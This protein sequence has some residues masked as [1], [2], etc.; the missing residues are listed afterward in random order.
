MQG[1]NR[2]DRNVERS[3][4]D[5]RPTGGS[6]DGGA[7]GG[8]RGGKPTGKPG[9]R[10]GGKP[11]GKP[12]ARSGGRPGDK[13]G[14]RPGGRPTGKP[15]PRPGDRDSRTSRP[16]RPQ[17]PVIPEDVDI[18]DLDP[19]VLNE[20]RTL[21]E[22][23]R[24]KVAAHLAAAELLLLD[25]DDQGARAHTKE[26]KR[27]A[28][29]VAAVR[30]AAGIT[31]YRC[32]DYAD[33]LAELRA[34]RRMTGD[35]SF[36]PMMADCE[37]GLGRP[38]RA[39]ELLREIRGGDPALKVEAQIVAAGARSDM[40]QHEAALVL[41]DIPELTSLPAGTERARLQYAYASTLEALGRD[42]ESREWF[43]KAAESDIDEAT[44]ASARTGTN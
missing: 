18:E 2:E 8:K 29:R 20:L 5:R 37:R 22:E 15:G 42:A 38:E 40:G 9:P 13:P 41:L 26:A 11:N 33:A 35:D 36:V 30:E 10:S 34:V 27:L 3:G 24:D 43:A 25:E 1:Q 7:R 21:P 16:P 14:T 4:S 19:A 39:L 32:G 31:A 6:A 17:G 12:G 23:L 28:G 44:D